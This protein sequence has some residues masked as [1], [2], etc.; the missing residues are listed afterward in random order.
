MYAI[1]L[2]FNILLKVIATVIKQSCGLEN[3]KQNYQ[4]SDDTIAF[5]KVQ[6]NSQTVWNKK[7]CYNIN[8]QNLVEPLYISNGE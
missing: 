4:Y 5:V 7:D 1:K 8:T 3:E 6:Q 2:L